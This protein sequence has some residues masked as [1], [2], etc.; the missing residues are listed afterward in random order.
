MS[1]A[2]AGKSAGGRGKKAPK[3]IT[4]N[5]LH[6][7]GLHYLQRFATGTENFRRVMLRKVERSC[8]HHPEQNREACAQL[9]EALIEKFSQAGLLDDKSYTNAAV[10]S[11]RRRGESSRAIAARLRAKGLPADAVREA[12]DT[13][14]SDDDFHAALRFARRRRLGPFAAGRAKAPE[15]QMAA[16]ARAGHG[17]EI[18]AKVLRMERDE[19]EQALTAGR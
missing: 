16:F 17:Y 1:G 13:G 6:N 8:R 18:A 12:L 11:L 3:K 14:D 5:Y 4:E 19:A 15:K 2:S 7:S 9:V 10:A